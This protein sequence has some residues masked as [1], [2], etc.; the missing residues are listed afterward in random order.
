MLLLFLAG[1]CLG[2]AV[3]LGIYRLAYL[4]RRI[5]PWSFTRG[6]MPP[7]SWLDRIPIVGWWTLRRESAL[8]GRGFWIRPMLIELCFALGVPA[9][10]WWEIQ[11]F[12]LMLFPMRPTWHVRC[13]AAK[14]AL[15]CAYCRARVLLALLAVATFIDIDEQTIPD[16]VTVPGTLIALAL[17]AL[18]RR[19]LPWLE[20]NVQNEQ[21]QSFMLQP[22]RFDYPTARDG[23][24]GRIRFAGRG[25]CL[26][27]R[28]VRR[29]VAAALA[30]GR[31][32]GQ[33][34]GELCGG[35]SLARSEWKW[36]LPMAV[37]GCRGIVL[38]WMH[39]R[40]TLASA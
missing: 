9:L 4:R 29:A 16:A 34:P 39:G 24:P 3:N 20:Q 15:L 14:A 36:V 17:A 35:A 40:R 30:T 28:L 22:L 10:Y 32:P 21:T 31:G 26:L 11:Q 1:A 5:S 18:P 23:V 2:A 12:A 7:R 13:L 27:S 25:D 19:T 37:V 33:R 6:L 8:H 38:L